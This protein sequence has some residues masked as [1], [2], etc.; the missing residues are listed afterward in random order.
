M[1]E[2]PIAAEAGIGCG[3][4]SLTSKTI[5]AAVIHPVYGKRRSRAGQQ[6][7]RETPLR[8]KHFALNTA[9]RRASFSSVTFL[10]MAGLMPYFGPEPMVT[11]TNDSGGTSRCPLSTIA[12]NSKIGCKASRARF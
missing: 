5:H 8:L 12:P 9:R 3:R 10:G 4:A 7:M 6:R 2:M 11:F 1:F